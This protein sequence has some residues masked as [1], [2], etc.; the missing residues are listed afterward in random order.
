MPS[1]DEVIVGAASTRRTR[2]GRCSRSAPALVSAAPMTSI[3]GS[4]RCAGAGASIPRSSS[5]SRTP[6]TPPHGS[7]RRWPRSA[8]RC[9]VISVAACTPLPALRST[10]LR[11]FD[12]AASC[13]STG[14]AAPRGCGRRSASTYDRLRRRPG[15]AG[16]G[17]AGQRA[18]GTADHDAQRPVMRNPSAPTPGRRSRGSCTTRRGAVRR[19]SWSQLV[20]VEL[21]NAWREA[22]AAVHRGGGEDSRRALRPRRR[23][24]HAAAGDARGPGPVRLLGRRSAAAG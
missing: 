18:P 8:G 17:G 5:G 15:R 9:C 21:G 6:W 11:S 13:W 22:Q 16:G 7:R 24:W 3:H 19:C 1:A 10:L 12:P 23:Q 14:L 4:S 20:V 2:P